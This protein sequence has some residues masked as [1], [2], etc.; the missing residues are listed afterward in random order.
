VRRLWP[1]AEAAQADYERLRA[2][3]LAGA[4][5]LDAAAA[6]FERDG[7]WGLIRRPQ[8]E[9][10]FAA[11]LHGSVRPAWTPYGDPRLDALVDA[12]QLVLAAPWAL[13]AR[14]GDGRTR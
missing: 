1:V 10:V 11:R 2:A 12:Y 4:T 14:T 5:P 9:A 6:R 8:A 3:V 7:M 13:S